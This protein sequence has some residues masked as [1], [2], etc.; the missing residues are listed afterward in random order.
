MPLF[1]FHTFLK[2]N[3][4]FQFMYPSRFTKRDNIM[5]NYMLEL[6]QQI[7]ITSKCD[8]FQGV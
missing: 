5:V 7:K 2:W 3:E 1:N 6:N 8:Y 4:K